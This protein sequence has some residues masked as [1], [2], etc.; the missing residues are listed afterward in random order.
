[1]ILFPQSE[2]ELKGSNIKE[3][4]NL[5]VLVR[6]SSLVLPKV[7][8]RRS[9]IF[10]FSKTTRIHLAEAQNMQKEMESKIKDK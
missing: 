1:M 7:T 4:G 9:L 8:L 3:E 6:N 2:A 10:L 5:F